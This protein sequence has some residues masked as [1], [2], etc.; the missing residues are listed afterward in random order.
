LHPAEVIFAAPYL[1]SLY[2][3]N[4]PYWARADF[5]RFAI[6]IIPFVFVA[7]WRWIPKDRRILWLLAPITAVL[8]A[9]SALGIRNVSHLLRLRA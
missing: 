9:S 3:Y 1:L 4:Y 8:A 7:L 6:P 5:P 2:C